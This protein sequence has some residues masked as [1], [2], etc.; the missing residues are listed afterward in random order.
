MLIEVMVGAVVLAIATTAILNGLDGAQSTGASNKARSVQATLAQQDIERMRAFPVNSLSNLRQTRT[1]AVAGVDYTVVSRTEWVR[2]ASGVVSCTSGDE[3]Q[4]QYLKLSSTVTSPTTVTR[5]VK[6]TGL[7]TPGAGQLS[8]T[9]GTATVKL[10]NRSGQP[11]VGLTVSLSGPGSHT[12]RTNELG[13]AVFGYIPA[14]TY[15]VQ[16]PGMV[17]PASVLPAQQDLAVYATK[18]SLAQMQVEQPANLRANFV[19]PVQ[20]GTPLSPTFAPSL[21]WDSITVKNAALPTVT[22]IFPRTGGIGPSVDATNLFPF[23]DGV[24]VYAGN[25]AA[26]DPTTYL[27]NYWVPGGRGHAAL[28]PGDALVPVDVEMPTLRV[29]VRRTSTAT[30]FNRADITLT[31]LDSGCAGYTASATFANKG[32]HDFDLAVPFGRYRVCVATRTGTSTTSRRIRTSASSTPP[33][34]NLTTVPA[35]P[36]RAITLTTGTS[37][38]GT[39]P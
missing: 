12:D 18:A 23:A 8:T 21:V 7:L 13:C 38:S 28:N 30:V 15:T 31:S 17:A 20:S 35:T 10:T 19:G 25:C 11:L 9:A 32:S 37:T 36:N 39:C 2:D 26:N 33:D 22:K 16:V 34:Q 29:T 6:E 27:P 5:P 4:G 3:T 1:V 14:G 24:G